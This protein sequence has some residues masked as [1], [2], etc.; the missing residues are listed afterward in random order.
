MRFT[1]QVVEALSPP[2]GKPYGLFWDDM[3]KGFG[4]KASAG[5]SRQYVAQYRTPDGRT[6]RVT[7]G[8]VDTLSLDEARK[9]ARAIL[10]KAQTGSDPQ[11]EKAEARRQA[12]ITLGSVTATYLAQAKGR[13]KPRS[14]QEVERHLMKAWAPLAGMPLNG[15]RRADVA[16]R[17]NVI[18]ETGKVNANRA[19]SALSGLYTW[20]IGEGTAETNPVAGTNKPT[21]EKPRERFLSREEVRAVWKACRDDDH[22]VMVRLLLLTAQRR[23][24]V[25]EMAEA[26]LDLDA[27]VWTLPGIRAKNG[28][29]HEI[30]LSPLAVQLL[31]DK[32]RLAGR[33]LVFG[34]GASGF[35]GWSNSKERLDARVKAAGADLAPW[36]L[37]DLRRTATTLMAEY[38]GVQPHIISAIKNHTPEGMARVYN[39]ATYRAEKRDALNR[40]ADEIG[41]LCL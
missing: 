13:L 7:I 29:T 32:P 28:R 15:I 1:K 26:E 38:V 3:L 20:A 21:D 34:Q 17:L 9:Q 6:P 36:T 27:A 30:P 5:G 41:R 19:R 22:G 18:A 25:G 31:R 40:W 4:V 39:L 24:E 16:A 23:N 35:S 11:A 37:H 2:P 8:R 14:Y 10:A 12:S 33:S